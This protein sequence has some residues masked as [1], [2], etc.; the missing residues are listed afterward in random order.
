MLESLIFLSI[1]P[2]AILRVGLMDVLSEVLQSLSIQ[3]TLACEAELTGPWG[4]EFGADEHKAGF[5]MLIR[6]SAYL[7]VDVYD[8]PIALRGGDMVLLPRGN[9]YI[10]KDQIDS[11]VVKIQSLTSCE[12]SHN[13][14]KI[15]AVHTKPLAV[16]HGGGGA[17]TTLIAGCFEYEHGRTNPLV[18]GF[19]PLI[20]V[21]AED[22]KAD[23]WLESTLRF[24][25]SEVFSDAQGSKIILARLADIVFTQAMRHYIKEVK[26]CPKSIGW[27]K[28]LADPALAQAIG[29]MHAQ[30]DAPWTVASLAE[31]I[32]LSRS[33]FAEKFTAMTGVSPMQY[34]TEWRMHCA[35]RMMVDKTLNLTE[36]A[37]RVGYQSE[38][39]F[40]KAFKRE[41]G[42]AP[43]SF[44]T[45]AMK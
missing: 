29:Y 21:K 2:E 9:A 25:A 35:Q 12:K 23:T 40:S 18:S 31:Q 14:E 11:P 10:L 16:K 20:V 41:V 24:I 5:L 19:P 17:P 38:A 7:E 15:P 13:T 6:G 32:G 30:P 42:V 43:G 1:R 45:L 28:A 27:L 4:I 37:E 33:S 3:S 36:I 8:K 39:A 34:L 44:R 22:G 26:N